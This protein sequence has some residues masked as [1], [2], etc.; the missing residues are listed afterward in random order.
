MQNFCNLAVLVIY[1]SGQSALPDRIHLAALRFLETSQVPDTKNQ[2]TRFP[3]RFKISILEEDVWNK[4]NPQAQAGLENLDPL[5][6]A[7]LQA[8]LGDNSATSG[9]QQ[10][11][12]GL[13]GDR[14]AICIIH[15]LPGC[16][17]KPINLVMKKPTLERHMYISFVYIYEEKRKDKLGKQEKR[18]NKKQKS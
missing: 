7:T 6:L 3:S 10:A 5:I 12:D 15:C 1:Q 9:T 4:M 17:E 8:N 2:T 14:K 13:E 11:P 16:L 18:T